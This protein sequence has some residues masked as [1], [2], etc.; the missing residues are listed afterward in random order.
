MAIALVLVAAGHGA[1][2]FPA[3]LKRRIIEVPD[4]EMDERDF[5]GWEEREEIWS[6]DPTI[7][8]TQV[9]CH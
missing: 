7:N 2:C 4:G 9:R 5:E 6:D 8:K 3:A 1:R